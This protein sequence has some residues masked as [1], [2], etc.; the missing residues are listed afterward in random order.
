VKPRG[1]LQAFTLQ[2]EH[3]HEGLTLNVRIAVDFDSGTA[4]RRI[5]REDG[6]EVPLDKLSEEE[7]RAIVR[8]LGHELARQAPVPAD[9]FEQQLEAE[10]RVRAAAEEAEPKAAP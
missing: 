9:W 4:T 8:G 10:R 5:V 1:P 6:V 3:E 7:Q 2:H